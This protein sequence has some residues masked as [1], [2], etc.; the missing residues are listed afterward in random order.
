M[1]PVNEF[2]VLVVPPSSSSPVK[3]CTTLGT[4]PDSPLEWTVATGRGDVLLVWGCLSF[5]KVAAVQTDIQND[6]I[7]HIS[8]GAGHYTAF[9]RQD[10]SSP[11]N[12]FNDAHV[13]SLSYQAPCRLQTPH[14]QV[15]PRLPE[16]EGQDDVYVLFYKR[17]GYGLSPSCQEIPISG[18]SMKIC[19]Q[20]AQAGGHQDLQQGPDSV[21]PALN[22]PID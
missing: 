9:A 18:P 11:W 15:D 21:Y 4:G 1:P 8:L 2:H 13:R 3:L 17:T 10:D 19:Q 7:H 5:W 12:Y 16:G 6:H 22:Y 14:L 20:Q